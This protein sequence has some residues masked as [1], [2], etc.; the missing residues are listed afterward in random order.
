MPTYRYRSS[1]AVSHCGSA[2]RYPQTMSQDDISRVVAQ[3][4][5]QVADE[6][7][8][9]ES[10]D[11]PWPRL[12]RVQAFVAPLPPGSKVLD[13]GC[14]NGLP[15]TRAV[16]QSH[17]VTGIDISRAQIERARANVPGVEFRVGDARTIDF[18]DDSRDAILALYLID[19]VPA[20]DY[21]ELFARFARWLKPGGRLLLSAEP[22]NDAGQEYEWLGVPMF[23]NTI[24]SSQ[25]Q[26]MLN[27]AS[28]LVVSAE[29][30]TQLEGGREIQFLWIEATA[31]AHT[32]R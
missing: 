4:Y 20:S 30:E 2:G 7:A 10:P 24:P 14:G 18:A 27:E 28:F 11:T 12:R 25:L 21:P 6:Y 3:G 22:G 15:A 1:A 8:A 31:A 32:D 5:D 29:L 19:N 26:T 16:A 9:L 13:L 17:A 23:I